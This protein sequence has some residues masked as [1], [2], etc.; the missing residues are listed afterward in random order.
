MQVKLGLF[1]KTFNPEMVDWKSQASLNDQFGVWTTGKRRFFVKRFHKLPPGWQLMK[2][3]IV[4]SF[5]NV[6]RVFRLQENN[7]LYYA[8]MEYLEGDTLFN[9][10]QKGNTFKYF[11]DSTLT[12]EHKTYIVMSI[13]ATIRSINLRGFWYPDLD[14]KNIFIVKTPKK[15]KVFLIDLDSCPSNNQSFDPSNVSQ[16]CWEGLVK[17]YQKYN[18]SFLKREGPNSIRITPKGIN[19]NQS[20]LVLFAHYIK[21]LGITPKD[22]PLYDPLINIKSPFSGTVSMIHL[23]LMDGKDCWEEAENFLCNYYSIP[24]NK[25]R[26]QH[27]GKEP[28]KTHW[29]ELFRKLKEEK[30]N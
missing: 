21:R 9:I 4:K 14:L 8:F 23:K 11:G 10:I 3:A 24:K 22:L 28:G 19:L 16:V 2:N 15:F 6:P 26:N 12:L 18:K 30:A 27:R 5:L 1:S 13:S 29:M 7:G 17:T 25:L 20:M